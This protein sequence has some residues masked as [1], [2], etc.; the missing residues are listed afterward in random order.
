MA[1]RV[2]HKLVVQISGDQAQKKKRFF[3][4]DG[5]EQETDIASFDRSVSG[6]LNI[7]D[8][9][10]EAL[11]FGDVTDARGIYLEVDQPC[12]MRINGSPTD[13]PIIL[14][15]APGSGSGAV[16][17]TAKVFLEMNLTSVT[18]ENTSGGAV[19]TGSYTIWGDPN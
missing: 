18:I 19:L 9:V 17:P 4:E 10:T 2:K 6:D 14:A 1:L 8:T 13:L 11:S 16:A 15:P 5:P 7:L 12:N 3:L